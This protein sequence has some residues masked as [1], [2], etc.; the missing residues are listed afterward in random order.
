M[1]TKSKLIKRSLFIM[2]LTL[3]LTTTLDA[4]VTIGAGEAPD[5][6]ALL[7][8]KEQ[9]DNSSTKGLLLPRVA[10]SSTTLATPMSQHVSGMTV[11]NTQTTGDVTPGYYYNDGSKWLKL[12]AGESSL[13]PRFFHMPSAVL[14][15]DTSDSAYDSGTQNFVVDLYQI[16]KEQFGL[17]NLI[18]SSKN[19]IATTLPVLE[20]S[21]LECFVTY[22]DN[23]VFQN[24]SLSDAGVLTYQVFSEITTSDKTFMNIVFKVK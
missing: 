2:A 8:L 19:P 4:Q 18:S 13:M 5:S 17:E 15:T 24:V 7:D 11:Y 21:G 6:D 22:Y 20:S 16:Y 12:L 1:K 23:S 10:L 3:T 9:S 14:P